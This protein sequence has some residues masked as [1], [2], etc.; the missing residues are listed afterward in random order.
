MV[1]TPLMG[2]HCG[3]SFMSF[4]GESLCRNCC[5]DKK[6]QKNCSQ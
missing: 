3:N 1:K 4:S 2:M 5:E 6:S